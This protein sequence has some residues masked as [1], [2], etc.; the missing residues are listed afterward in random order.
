MENALRTECADRI[1]RITPDR[2]EVH[3]AFDDA[4]IARLTG[5]LEQIAGDAHASVV[6][7]RGAGRDGVAAFLDKCKPA[8][9]T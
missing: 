6:E 7:L 8:W 9:P 1:A 2:P 3:D 5:Q 4:L